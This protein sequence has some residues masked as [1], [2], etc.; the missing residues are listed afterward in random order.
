MA[1]N[2]V[3]L[4]ILVEINDSLKNLNKI[5]KQTKDSTKSMEGAFTALKAAAVAGLAFVA[6]KS[7]VNF[8]SEGVDAALK[9]EEALANL[10]QQ[11]KLTGEFTDT[12][13]EGFKSFAD[14]MELTSTFADDAVLSQL[15]LAK[16]FGVSNDQAKQLVE[17]AIQ[18][19]SATGDDLETS[20][21]ALG[22]T[23]DGTAGKLA[24]T[25]PELRGMSKAALEAHGAI[26]VVLERFQGSSLAK[27]DTF[28]GAVIQL[29]NAFGNLQESFGSIIIGNGPLIELVKSASV[30]FGKLQEIVEKNREALDDFITFGVKAF[31]V[32]I[33]VALE[34][35]GFFVRALEGLAVVGGL[36]FGGLI[37]VVGVFYDAWR[38]TIG[39]AVEV[40]LGFAATITRTVADTPILGSVLEMAG[41]DTRAAAT[42]ID[43]IRDD[44]VALAGDGKT[45]IDGFRDSV[46]TSTGTMVEK[47]EGLNDGFESFQKVV[48]DLAV[49]IF[50]SDQ[51]IIT[52]AKKVAA[53]RAEIGG[54]GGVKDTGFVGPLKP[55]DSGGSAGVG[56]A[57]DKD[58]LTSGQKLGLAIAGSIIT[59]IGA[60]A[61]GAAGAVA[62]A[63]GLATKGLAT[64]F[65]ANGPLADALGGTLAQAFQILGQDPAAFTEMING[66]L[67]G[68]PTIIDNI[69][70]NIPTLVIA[71]AENLGP[72]ITALLAA[73]PRI[74]VA[75]VQAMPQVAKAILTA[76]GEGI[77]FQLAKLGGFLD[78]VQ[79]IGE[80][81]KGYF[82]D[83]PEKIS[84]AFKNI[85][86][87]ISEAFGGI[88]IALSEGLGTFF[89][90]LGTLL[91]DALT[92]A[93][94]AFLDAIT[95]GGGQSDS[96]GGAI[97]GS[98]FT[99][100]GFA[101]GGDV[102]SGF[103][104]DSFPARLTSGEA[105]L[106]TNTTDRLARFLDK[107]EAGDNSQ[108]VALMAELIAATRERQQ[109]VELRLDGNVLAKTIL[110]LNS[111]NARMAR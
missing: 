24:T 99:I 81:V 47:F 26:G 82:A 111:R 80:T 65:G 13:V 110:G 43:T 60:G 97:K 32:A 91:I 41:V 29:K 76:F 9:Q 71:I 8:F 105:V 109:P 40:I 73:V 101:R 59:G 96:V 5:E 94:Q 69:V 53:A 63:F 14:Q 107:A 1:D 86:A 64:L 87:F 46:L 4:E 17:A 98:I 39:L 35:L 52:S 7:L 44:F 72:I 57:K 93:G 19:S 27:I 18:L 75:L 30:V 56:G 79:E 15:A 106:T 100:P 25:I 16:S 28:G 12:A 104:D 21:R 84:A 38:H 33:P 37:T 49:A 89:R 103:P 108:L 10:T 70:A 58:E 74:V 78:K 66:F 50:A 22:G 102:P 83:I 34:V 3:S 48:D 23:L 51:K 55:G 45:A 92:Q 20:V 90:S 77:S 42:S 11:M 67:K 68:I 31:A 2:E 85:G 6:S 54:G 88:G 61:D 95:P 62:D 36:A